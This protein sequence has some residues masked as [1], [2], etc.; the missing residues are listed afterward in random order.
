MI[1]II[2]ISGLVIISNTS[3][4]VK[5]KTVNAI[6]KNYETELIYAINNDPTVQNINNLN[7]NFI[8]FIN[9][10]NFD[11]KI[12]NILKNSQ[13][14]ILSNF[15]NKD[16]NLMING[17]LNQ[18]ISNNTTIAIDIFINDMNIY[19]CNCYYEGEKNV[20]YL[21]IYN[22]SSETIFKN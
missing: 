20:Y 21:D 8:T 3:P 9:S 15:M 12:C 5:T 16:C 7:K 14:L 4:K 22:E 11:A 10:N 1:I 19:L 6:A 13:E 18:I 17:D 2:F